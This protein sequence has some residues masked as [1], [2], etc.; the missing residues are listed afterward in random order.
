MAA[1]MEFLIL[2][3]TTLVR[4]TTLGNTLEEL[5]GGILESYFSVFM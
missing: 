3:C 1:T 2:T 5:V 4:L